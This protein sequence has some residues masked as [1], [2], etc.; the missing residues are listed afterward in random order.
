MALEGDVPAGGPAPV[1]AG[2]VGWPGWLSQTLPMVGDPHCGR[3]RPLST[4]FPESLV[5][6]HTN[7]LC[8]RLAPD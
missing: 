4:D 8:G 7:H 5:P 1:G 3:P 6:S 2:A